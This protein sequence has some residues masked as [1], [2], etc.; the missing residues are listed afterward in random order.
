[1]TEV[2]DETA[3][4]WRRGNLRSRLLRGAKVLGE[5]WR[6]GARCAAEWSAVCPCDPQGIFCKAKERWV[7]IYGELHGQEE[8]AWLRRD[9]GRFG[10]LLA[11]TVRQCEAT[12][13]TLLVEVPG[14]KEPI[15]VGAKGTSWETLLDLAALRS[16]PDYNDALGAVLKIQLSERLSVNYPAL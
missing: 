3:E 14:G 11:M 7:K 4:A 10:L 12:G 2:R 6:S 16:T 13:L 5:L 9:G 15:R 8:V 1:V